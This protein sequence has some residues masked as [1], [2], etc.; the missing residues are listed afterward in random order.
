MPLNHSEMTLF[1]FFFFFFFFLRGLTS[2]QERQL[3][4]SKSCWQAG[5]MICV[6]CYKNLELG[7]R[8]II[9]AFFNSRYGLAYIDYKHVL[10]VDASV[11]V[12]QQGSSRCS[13]TL[14][15]LQGYSWREKL[16]PMVTVHSS[17]IPIIQIPPEAEMTAQDTGSG[18]PKSITKSTDDE[19]KTSKGSSKKSQK[20][21]EKQ[22]STAEKQGSTPEK[23]A[24][25][26]LTKE[27]EFDMMKAKGN[28]HVKNVND[29]FN[30]SLIS[31][32]D[33]F[34]FSYWLDSLMFS[35]LLA[36]IYIYF[37]L[38][39]TLFSPQSK[40]AVLWTFELN[41]ANLSKNMI[42]HTMDTFFIGQNFTL[43][44]FMASK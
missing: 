16:P 13:Q 40:L 42:N 6:S 27:E 30:F 37:I 12:A 18:K 17:D 29:I 20:K 43:N 36:K 44:L 1:F 25:K 2:L 14:I 38:D 11:E 7:T 24:P 8:R 3:E 23:K 28:Q 10:A 5:V 22:S 21:L 32:D 19:A 33:A 4:Y 34:F 31:F 9:F 41:I 15:Q 26:T 35:T 39:F